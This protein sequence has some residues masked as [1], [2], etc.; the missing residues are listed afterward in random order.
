[1]L[2]EFQA[3]TLRHTKEKKAL[4]IVQHHAINYI[5]SRSV[6]NLEVLNGIL[7]QLMK[8]E[9]SVYDVL[10]DVNIYIVQ[11]LYKCDVVCTLI[12]KNRDL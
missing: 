7:L 2:A 11:S 12:R 9:W 8:S 6:S 4:K 5:Q 10:Q 3:D 1:M